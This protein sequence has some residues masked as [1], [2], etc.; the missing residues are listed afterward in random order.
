MHPDGFLTWH[1]KAAVR[2][3]VDPGDDPLALGA[4]SER[5]EMLFT[6]DENGNQVNEEVTGGTQYYAMSYYFPASWAGTQYSWSETQAHDAIDCT[7]G[8]Q[9]QCNSWSYVLQFHTDS[10]FWGALA[11]AATVHGGPQKYW[12]ML[13]SEY[14]FSDGGIIVLGRWTDLVLEIDWGSGVIA[15][16]RRDEGQTGFTEVVSATESTVTSVSGVYLKQG[17][18]R[19]GYVAGRS[20]V[21]WI[22]PT[23]RGSSFSAVEQAAFA[24]NVGP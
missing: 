1:G 24:T 20:D 18:Y 7:T 4:N 21:F 11:A 15:L 17:L 12:F 2:V 14:Q 13:G 8:D 16:W 10:S 22:G 3:E 9:S 5:A 23:A 19:G 6:Q